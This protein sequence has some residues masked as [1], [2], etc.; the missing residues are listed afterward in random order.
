MRPPVGL[1]VNVECA[2]PKRYPWTCPRPSAAAHARSLDP[3]DPFSL[4]C[5]VICVAG[6]LPEHLARWL[7]GYRGGRDFRFP[8]QPERGLQRAELRGRRRARVGHHGGGPQSSV[9]RLPGERECSGDFNVCHLQPNFRLRLPGGH[10]PYA[11]PLH[12]SCARK[13][14]WWCLHAHMHYKLGSCRHDPV[15]QLGCFCCSQML[16]CAP[17]DLPTHAACS[18]CP[19]KLPVHMLLSAREKYWAHPRRSWTWS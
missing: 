19:P 4:P 1:K 8:A 7:E 13:Q 6:Q 17:C 18:R 12:G 11:K 3:T 5:S 10:W 14:A 2:A 15:L 9:A 16:C